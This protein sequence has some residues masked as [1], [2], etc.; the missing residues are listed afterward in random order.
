M[1]ENASSLFKSYENKSNKNLKENLDAFINENR[2]IWR[3][4]LDICKDDMFNYL[5]CDKQV[6]LYNQCLEEEPIYIPRKFWIDKVSTMN[7]LEKNIYKK[8]ALEQTSSRKI[9]NRSGNTN[10]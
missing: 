4:K 9:K 5:T 2:D 1:E 10:Q 6:L 8:L 3:S 7:D